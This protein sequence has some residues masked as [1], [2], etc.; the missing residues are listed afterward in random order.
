MKIKQWKSDEFCKMAIK[1]GFTFNRQTGSHLIYTNKDG[2]HMSIPLNLNSLIAKRLIKENG[3]IVIG[4]K[5]NKN[6]KQEAC[7]HLK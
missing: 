5:N 2:R 4:K 3:L 6:K 7:Y 1:N